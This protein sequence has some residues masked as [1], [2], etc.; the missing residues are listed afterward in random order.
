MKLLELFK[1]TGSFG[2]AAKRAGIS[3]TSLDNESKYD[4]DILTDILKWDYKSLD[5]IPDIITASP[6]CATFSNMALTKRTTYDPQKPP[7]VR[8][9]DSM[10]PLNSY[11]KLGDNLL[12]RTIEIINYYRK[13]NPKLKFIVENPHGS[14]WKSPLMVKLLPYSTAR[15]YYCL[16][17]DT[18]TKL[19][20]F[21]NNFNLQLQEGTCRGTEQVLDMPLCRRYAIPQKLIN[22]IFKQVKEN[23]I[24]N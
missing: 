2:K 11:A 14:M 15:T 21:F 13:K 12:R 3:V 1:G 18:R 4:P 24:S 9:S 22:S 23:K 5:F 7:R 8:N 6:P 19:T 10:K 20:D 17:G 16:Y